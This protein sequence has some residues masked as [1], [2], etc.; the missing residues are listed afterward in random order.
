MLKIIFRIYIGIIISKVFVACI[1]WR[2][3][4]DYVDF[5]SMGVY[6]GGKGFE[7]VAL[8]KNMVGSIGT[9]ISQCS[10]LVLD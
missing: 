7:V 5:T 10:F 2:I 4:I 3:Y 9:G 6:E 8:D 1:V